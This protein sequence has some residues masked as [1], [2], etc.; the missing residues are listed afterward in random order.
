MQRPAWGDERPSTPRRG[1]WSQA[2]VSRLKELYGLRD[3][4]AIARELNRSVAS[5]RSMAEQLFELGVRTGPW[6]AE[7]VLRLKR[8]LGGTTPLVI[9]RILGRTEEEVEQ[10]VAE[11]K[12]VQ[13]SGRWTQEEINEFKRLYG[14]RTDEDLA[15]VFGRTLDSIRRMS[16]RLC[17]AKDKAFL[18]RQSGG[19]ATTR[20]PR[21]RREELAILREE[22]DPARSIIG[23]AARS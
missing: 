12:R 6:S 10:R 14:T 19:E 17:I 21:W 1:R 18:R 7:E 5:V 20:M 3:E 2:E 9:A 13:S 23:K 4:T 16:Q 8:Y 11:L 22:V 15:L